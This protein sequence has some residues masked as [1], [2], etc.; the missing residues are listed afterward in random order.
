MKPT[1]N[2][3]DKL[4]KKALAGHEVTPDA[5]SW[6]RLSRELPS[7]EDTSVLPWYLRPGKI[8]L[9]GLFISAL[10]FLGGYFFASL[11]DSNSIAQNETGVEQSAN[12]NP[13]NTFI[14]THTKDRSHASQA[15]ESGINEI[16][17]LSNDHSSTQKQTNFSSGLSTTANANARPGAIATPGAYES[18]GALETPE[19]SVLADIGS[20]G[21]DML[22]AYPADIALL[23]QSGFPSSNAKLPVHPFE[24][25]AFRKNSGYIELYADHQFGGAHFSQLSDDYYRTVQERQNGVTLQYN[26]PLGNRGFSLNSGFG[27]HQ[28]SVAVMD[29]YQYRVIVPD[30][31][32]GGGSIGG[33]VNN[34]TQLRNYNSFYTTSRLSVP[35]SVRYEKQV[36]KLAVFTELGPQLNYFAD[37]LKSSNRGQS[38]LDSAFRQH[39]HPAEIHNKLSVQ[40]NATLGMAVA[41]SD[42]FDVMARA[43]LFTDMRR[44]I[45]LQQTDDIRMIG[46][47]GVRYRL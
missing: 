14:A 47:L 11:N 10:S 27:L 30:S 44:S 1:L 38:L 24:P 3:I 16:S 2:P 12:L 15:N 6:A 43:T 37:G 20:S 7:A 28:V 26:R 17:S 5:D 39:E 46:S 40:L 8:V 25:K 22:F 45:R 23:V 9:A 34:S 35:L 36:S 13:G 21:S 42:N 41:V 4:V 32:G 33:E 31:I 19:S 18:N 29:E